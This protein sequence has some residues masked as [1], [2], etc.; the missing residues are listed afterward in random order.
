MLLRIATLPDELGPPA[1]SPRG[2]QAG[3]IRA[4]RRRTRRRLRPTTIL[5]TTGL[6][7]VLFFAS[8][9]TTDSVFGTNATLDASWQWALSYSTY[10]HVQFGSQFLFTYGPLGFLCSTLQGGPE[11]LWAASLVANVLARLLFLFL[12]VDVVGR[13]DWRQRTTPFRLAVFAAVAAIVAAEVVHQDFSVVISADATLFALVFMRAE[14]GSSSSWLLLA[15]STGSLAAGSLSKSSLYL[16]SAFIIGVVIAFIWTGAGTRPVKSLILSLFAVGSY[17]TWWCALWLATFQSFGDLATYV[18]GSS[19]IVIGYGEAMS[20]Q[21]FTYQVILLL[22]LVACAGLLLVV[23]TVIQTF[24]AS[25]GARRR[26]VR[27]QLLW[28]GV[29]LAGFSFFYWKEGIVRQDP[30]SGNGHV[31]AAFIG[32]AFGTT[33]FLAYN[34]A[35]FVPRRVTTA[36]AVI[37]AAIVAIN[38]PSALLDLNVVNNVRQ[39]GVG[40]AH[41]VDP[42]LYSRGASAAQAELRHHYGLPTRMIGEIGHHRIVVLPTNLTLGPA[43]HL[44]EVL[45]PVAQTYSAYTPMLD[46]LDANYLRTADVPFVLLQFTDI[47]D[48]YLLWSAPATYDELLSRYT[49]IARGNGYLLFKLG[50]PAHSF[51]EWTESSSMVIGHWSDVPR[52]VGG[53]ST[54]SFEMKPTLRGALESLVFRYPAV[55]AFVRVGGMAIGPYRFVWSASNDGL[56]MSGYW[57]PSS[58]ASGPIRGDQIEA[59]KI[60]A[61]HG[62]FKPEPVSVVYRCTTP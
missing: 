8:P 19:Q 4:L 46:N 18:R 35:G 42:V 21:G 14:P 28:S 20:L 3:Q 23:P 57:L 54:A 12:F 59:F 33:V 62:W 38:S 51:L 53:S 29:M 16:L 9:F 11:G 30:V 40:L 39:T 13:P 7:A 17:C 43:Y 45:L 24:R 6:A 1:R 47:D 36:T 41:V 15:L 2:T 22:V 44:E 34:A 37:L 56:S 10:H 48:R 49:L 32:I 60:E 50:Q 58:P 31:V 25:P 52:C 61:P 5:V 27:S 55:N 26:I